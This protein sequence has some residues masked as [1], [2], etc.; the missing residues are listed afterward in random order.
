MNVHAFYDDGL[1]HLSYA[2][3]S[4]GEIAL[5]DPARNPGPYLEF[6]SNHDARITAIIETHP[7]ADFVSSHLELHK[8]NN[9]PVY[10]SKAVGAGYPHIPFDDGERIRVGKVQLQAIHTPGHSP[11]SISIL[12]SDKGEKP[13]AIFTGDTLFVGDVGRPDLRENVGN[14]RTEARELARQLYHTTRN[15][16]MTLPGDVIVYPAH[17]PGSLCGK[18]I[19]SEL[20]STIGKEIRENYALQ[21]MSEQAFVSL[22]LDQQPFVPK[23]FS[24]NV[25][26]NKQGAPSYLSSLKKVPLLHNRQEM[27]PHVL[28]VDGRPA[29]KYRKGHLPGA[30]NIPIGLKFETWL[31]SVVSPNERFY[32][33]ADSEDQRDILL[34]K[35]AKIG[36]ELL[37]EATLVVQSGPSVSA[38]FDIAHFAAHPNQYTVVDIRNDQEHAQGPIVKHALHIPLHELRERASEIPTDKPVAVHCAGGYRSAIGSSILTALLPNTTVQD[39]STHIL[40][41]NRAN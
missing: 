6:A 21:P 27:N 24:Y 22:I 41:L 23:Y 12:L 29:E 31:G 28:V 35:A 17:G 33:I 39:I 15:K 2:I 38:R 11:D 25:L 7:H 9:A 40:D 34:A 8:L 5:I 13:Y 16:L 4:A 3:L 37:V 32:L 1:S 14:I 18:N 36:Y 10:T 30:I 26:L 20:E 19:G